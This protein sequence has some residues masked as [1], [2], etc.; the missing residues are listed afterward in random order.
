MVFFFSFIIEIK[1]TI[2]DKEFTVSEKTDGKFEYELAYTPSADKV[3]IR[4]DRFTA[5]TPCVY[6]IKVQ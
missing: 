2:E 3:R 4:F 6:S 5:N 1:I